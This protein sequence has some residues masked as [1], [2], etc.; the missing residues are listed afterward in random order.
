L[1]LS[2]ATKKQTACAGCDLQFG[3]RPLKR[4]NQEHLLGP[5]AP[6]LLAGEFKPGDRIKASAH[7]G[8]LVFQKK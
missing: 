1:N 7:D 4:T 2:A 3:A 5:L 8:Q 6:K